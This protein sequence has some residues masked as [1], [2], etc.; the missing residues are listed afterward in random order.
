MRITNRPVLSV[1]V[2]H[3]SVLSQSVLVRYVAASYLTAINTPNQTTTDEEPE[4]RFSQLSH[5]V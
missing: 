5:M 2:R 1:H 4:I 3:S